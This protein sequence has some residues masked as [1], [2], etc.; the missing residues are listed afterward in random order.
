MLYKKQYQEHICR[1]HLRQIVL[2]VCRHQYPAIKQK[3]RYNPNTSLN[4][5]YSERDG[6]YQK[7]INFCHT[8]IDSS[9]MIN[10]TQMRNEMQICLTFAPWNWFS[11]DHTASI[12]LSP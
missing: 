7:K 9:Y 2:Y 6:S 3:I 1:R 12:D 10:Q 4:N 11:Y 8:G 5:I